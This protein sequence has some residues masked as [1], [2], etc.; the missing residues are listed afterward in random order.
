[1]NILLDY[2]FKVSSVT[3]T[4]AASTGFLKD[5]CVVVKPKNGVSTGTITE[6]AS[7]SAVAALTDNAEVAQL[8]AAGMTKV[9]IL[10][11]DD[12]DLADAL[13]GHES[14]FYTLLISSDFD[15]DD[16][17]GVVGV[18]AEQEVKS[19]VKV[20]DITYTSKLTGDSGDAITIIYN[21]TKTDGS[22]EANVTNTNDIA[23]EIEDGVTT[24]AAIKAAIEADT[25]ANALVGAVVDSGD[26]TDPQAS[27]TPHV[28]LAGGNDAV[29]GTTVGA[30][31]IGQFSGVVGC[32]SDDD[33]VAAEYA[34]VANRAGFFASASNK[35]KN[36]FFAFGS[37]LS[38]ALNWLNQQYITMPLSDGVATLGDAESLFDD[39]VSFVMSDSEY[40][41]RLALFACGA[42]AIVAPYVKKNLEIDM[43]SAALSFISGNQPSYTKKYATLLENS[44]KDVVALYVERGWID[45]GTVEVRLEQSNFV[46]SGYINIAEPKALWRV[47]AEMRQTL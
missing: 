38:N 43:Q 3:P 32:Q 10:P 46:A 34:A 36:M 17:K 33:A 9:L 8:F 47:F 25:D 30:M 39:K 20:Q 22:A 19:S 45:A 11:M 23:V 27:F 18:P 15:D 41:N 31:D 1:M 35:A 40:G 12:L 21:D 4:A 13:E 44:L 37:L 16:I 2:V 14:D 7:T 26:E 29:S 6:C 24:A 28:H 5:V 42:K